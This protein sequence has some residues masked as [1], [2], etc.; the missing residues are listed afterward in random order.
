[1]TYKCDDGEFVMKVLGRF[2]VGTQK[3]I[4]NLDPNDDESWD[5]KS[6]VTIPITPTV[7]DV[8]A[9]RKSAKKG[10]AKRVK[11][12]VSGPMNAKLKVRRKVATRGHKDGVY[13]GK[14]PIS[15]VMESVAKRGG[16]QLK[17]KVKKAS[18]C[19]LDGGHGWKMTVSAAMA[20]LDKQHFL[21]KVAMK[22]LGKK[23]D[24]ILVQTEVSGECLRC[25]IL[26]N[27]DQRYISKE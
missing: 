14:R 8:Y 17:P 26:A 18:S 1:M 16:S 19:F 9:T 20:N 23:Q 15:D 4:I 24:S 10:S 7:S 25:R 5:I 21:A 13:D 6:A 11:P 22:A 3:E 27:K 2:K 12:E